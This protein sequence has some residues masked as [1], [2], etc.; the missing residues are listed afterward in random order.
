MCG[1]TF[2]ILSFIGMTSSFLLQKI[3]GQ[4]KLV[5]SDNLIVVTGNLCPIHTSPSPKTNPNFT[6]TFAQAV[7]RASDMKHLEC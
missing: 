5:N 2:L 6:L 4:E 7:T 3:R 1:I